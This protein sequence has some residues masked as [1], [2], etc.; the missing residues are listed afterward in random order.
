[1]SPAFKA[2]AKLFKISAAFIAP[3]PVKGKNIYSPQRHRVHREKNK[4]PK[5]LW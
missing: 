2:A 3:S 4:Y 1:M 5:T